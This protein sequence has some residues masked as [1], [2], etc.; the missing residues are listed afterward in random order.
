MT[1]KDNFPFLFEYFTINN[2]CIS[3]VSQSKT[4]YGRYTY[5]NAIILVLNF[6]STNMMTT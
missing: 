6:I 3:G 5:P 1:E 4:W 2:I